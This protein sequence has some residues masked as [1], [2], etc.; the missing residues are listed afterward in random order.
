MSA[1]GGGQQHGVYQLLTMVKFLKRLRTLCEWE[2]CDGNCAH[3]AEPHS[4]S[5][6]LYTL[7]CNLAGWI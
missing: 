7:L 6:T 1:A 2:L 4:G 3:L 5:A